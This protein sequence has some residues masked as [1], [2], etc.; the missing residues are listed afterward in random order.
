MVGA[1]FAQDASAPVTPKITGY[2]YG[3]ANVLA[4]NTDETVSPAKTTY[5]QGLGP[6]WVSSGQYATVGLSFTEKLWGF[7]GTIEYENNAINSPF[8]DYTLW[9]KPFG[10]VLKL[11]TGKLRNGD[12]RLTSYIDGSGFN[13][14]IANA[15][16]GI[17]AQFYP[18][19][20]LSIGVFNWIDPT[21][22]VPL[23]TFNNLNAG[24]S[25]SVDGLGKFVAAAKRNTVVVN[26]GSAKV[27][28][29]YEIDQDPTSPTYGQ[30]VKIAEK[31][32]VDLTTVLTDEYFVGFDLQAIKGLVAR[33]GA[34]FDL[35]EN[36]GG[37]KNNKWTKFWATA[38][39]TIADFDLGVDAYYLKN[40]GT[41]VWGKAQ[42]AYN[43]IKA[44][45]P[46]VYGY[47]KNIKGYVKNTT[48]ADGVTA[49]SSSD[50]TQDGTDYGF[51]ASIAVPADKATV[52]VGFDYSK[53][54]TASDSLGSS[55]VFPVAIEISF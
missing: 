7:S 18:V 53:T 51:G 12:Y 36:T 55:L 43:G 9:V 50:K 29:H 5:E 19:K 45:T 11:S 25:Y 39:Y 26:E 42:V 17:M 54:K 44:F 24:I 23:A 15:E 34:T 20:G 21:G 33:V 38:G 28:E 22:K 3:A 48:K 10:D 32:A 8:R 35:T 14:R 47:V 41:Q 6:G 27:K 16:Y 46:S 4:I 52:Y 40:S 37:A 30:L 2:F 49:L 31:A 13:T 1:V